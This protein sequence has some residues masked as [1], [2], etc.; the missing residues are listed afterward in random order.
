MRG[1]AGWRAPI[2]VLTFVLIFVLIGAT[3]PVRAQQANDSDNTAAEIRGLERAWSEG[4]ARNDNRAL[5]L[6]F[7]NALVYIEYGKVVTK[8]EYLSRIRTEIP[9]QQQ[10]V[11]EGI[12]VRAFGTTAIVVGVYREKDVKDG[13]VSI[14]RWRFIDTW[15]KKQGSWLLVAAGS[16]PLAK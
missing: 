1:T 3:M 15:V 8:G 7:D 12:T 10:I 11:M 2:S 16:A 5:D 14:S 9:H 4:E 13:K 6:I